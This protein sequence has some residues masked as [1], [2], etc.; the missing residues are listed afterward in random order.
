MSEQK[1]EGFDNEK[2]LKTEKMLL[3]I[4]ESD[5]SKDEILNFITDDSIQLVISYCR[6]ELLP[7]P[8]FGLIPQIV[9]D[10]YRMQGYGSE[11]SARRVKSW[12]QGKR[13]ETYEDSN[14][15]DNHFLNDYKERLAPFINKKGVV[16]S[17]ISQ[18]A[19][20]NGNQ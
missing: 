4:K 12:T 9:A 18:D 1:I 14:I 20:Y 19:T 15:Y 8:L 16:P 7:K 2:V 13:S 11:E 3:G 10:R 6:T 5:N 17:D